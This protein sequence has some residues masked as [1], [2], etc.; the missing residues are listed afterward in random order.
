MTQIRKHTD[1]NQSSTVYV[2]HRFLSDQYLKDIRI[3]LDVE[4]GG[5]YI[6]VLFHPVKEGES[7]Q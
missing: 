5:F 6:C 1:F 7:I 3:I 4:F 2:S